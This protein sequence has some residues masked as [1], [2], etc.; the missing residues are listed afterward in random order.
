MQILF[1]IRGLAQKLL[2]RSCLSGKKHYVRI[3]NHKSQLADITPR[4]PQSSSLEPSLFLMHINDL[5]ESSQFKTYLF[6]DDTSLTLSDKCLK[7]T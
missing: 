3:S 1:G 6:A 2:D 4:M 5:T 7:K